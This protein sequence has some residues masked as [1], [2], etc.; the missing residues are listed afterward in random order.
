MLLHEVIITVSGYNIYIAVF[1]SRLPLNKWWLLLN[2]MGFS[3]QVRMDGLFEIWQDSEAWKNSHNLVSYSGS[4]RYIMPDPV[5]LPL[6]L[7]IRRGIIRDNANVIESSF[8]DYKIIASN[9]GL[10]DKNSS[11]SQLLKN[12]MYMIILFIVFVFFSIY[13]LSCSYLPGT[14]LDERMRVT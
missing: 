14:V 9:L 13:L 8:Q 12:S 2:K 4:G 5:I 7:D 6:R 1:G 10:C 11:S 3:L